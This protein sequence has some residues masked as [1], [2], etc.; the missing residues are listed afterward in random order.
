MFG[1]L[2]QIS[3]VALPIF[4]LATMLNVGMT[5]DVRRIVEHWRNWPFI[6]KVLLANFIGAPLAMWLL[7]HFWPM[8][9]TFKAALLLFSLSAGAPMLIKL[10]AVSGHD[11]A[12]GASTMM[13]LV[14]ATLA[15]VPVAL[16]LLL[17]ELSVDGRALAWMLVRQLLVPMVLGAWLAYFAP[18]L[19]SLFQPWIRRIGNIALYVLLVSIIVGYLP[20]MMPIIRSGALI[21]GMIFI[22]V[23]FGLGWLA[24]YGQ[25]HLEDIG[26]LATA[27]RNTAASMLIASGGFTDPDVFVLITLVNTLG[28]AL[29]IVIAKGLKRDNAEVVLV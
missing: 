6:L 7:L 25:D 21:L 4:I 9:L 5:Q 20:A 26:G 27:Q 11:L 10:T 8:P 16:P 23:A 24:G 19:N 14:L 1:L 2:I 28:L 13:L 18:S 15:I 29:L 22:L 17:P 3:Q 12:L